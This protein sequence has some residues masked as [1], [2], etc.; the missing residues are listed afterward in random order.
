VPDTYYILFAAKSPA[1]KFADY[2]PKL[3]S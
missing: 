1:G 2:P 3:G